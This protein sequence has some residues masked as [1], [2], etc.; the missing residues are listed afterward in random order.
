M[1]AWRAKAESI[2]RTVVRPMEADGARYALDEGPGAKQLVVRASNGDCADCVMEN[3]DLAR[4]LQE[5]VNR[6]DPDV[7]VT[8]VDA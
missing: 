4:L 1:D 8:V 2:V 6:V 7:V 5:A 3:D